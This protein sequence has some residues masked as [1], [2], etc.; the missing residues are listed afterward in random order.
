[1]TDQAGPTPRDALAS[2]CSYVLGRTVTP[3]E[4]DDNGEKLRAELEAKTRA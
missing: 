4:I 3:E 2:M 1:M